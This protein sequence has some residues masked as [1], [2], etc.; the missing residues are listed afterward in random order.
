[1]TREA[2]DLTN[3]CHRLRSSRDDYRGRYE[4]LSSKHVPNGVVAKPERAALLPG[5][6]GSGI[7]GNGFKWLLPA[8]A[9][10]ALSFFPSLKVSLAFNISTVKKTTNVATEGVEKGGPGLNVLDSPGSCCE[11]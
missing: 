9:S 11:S 1:M 4:D 5:D 2:G 7:G 10:I 6:A 3:H 8:V